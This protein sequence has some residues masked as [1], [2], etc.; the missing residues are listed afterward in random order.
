M[1]GEADALASLLLPPA[2]QAVVNAAQSLGAFL[3]SYGPAGAG[4][5]IG[6][7]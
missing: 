7:P 2:A 6:L 5:A 3:V 1:L 4:T